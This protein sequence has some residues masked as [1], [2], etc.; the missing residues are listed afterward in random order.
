MKHP[1]FKGI[2]FLW[3]LALALVVSLPVPVFAGKAINFEL[4]DI[5]G[6]ILH[7]SDFQGKWVLVNFWAPWCPI[8]VGE[9]ETLNSLNKRKDLVVIAVGLSYGSYEHA[10]QVF[11]QAHNLDVTAIV[12]GGRRRDP[13]SPFH[14]V[15]PVDFYPTS[16]L[17]DPTG[18]IVMFIP[19]Q[20][21]E[22]KMLAF[23]E[24]WKREHMRGGK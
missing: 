2:R 14:Q 1:S 7:L 4:T 21:K 15:G 17:Y 19:G 23:M 11:A 13:K 9:V 6:R 24:G 12:A 18:E 16:Y 8:C 10:V 3:A 5:T 22:G 20:I